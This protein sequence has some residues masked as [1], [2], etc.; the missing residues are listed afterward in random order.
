V[1]VIIVSV[2]LLSIPKCKLLSIYRLWGCP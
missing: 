1:N 2:N